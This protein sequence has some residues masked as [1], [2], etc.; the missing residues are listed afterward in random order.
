MS[1][2]ILFATDIHL[3][4]VKPVSRLDSDFLGGIIAKIEQIRE[5]SKNFDIVLLGGD[6]FDRPDSSHGVVTRAINVFYKFKTPVYS[7]V[8]NHDIYGYQGQTID[9]TA[10][11]VLIESGAVKKLDSI[12]MNNVAIYGLHA[13]DKTVWEVPDSVSTKVLVAHKMITNNPFPGGACHLISDVAN[14]TNA[15]L[16]LSGD[17]HYP[18]EVEIN[19]K[20]FLNPG[21][22][23]RL[24]ITDRDRFPQVAEITIEDSGDINYNLR[25]LDSRPAETVFDLANYS[26]RLASEEHTKHFVKTYAQAVI[27]VKAEAHLLAPMLE[28]FLM[29]NGVEARLHTMVDAYRDRA[30]KD[31]LTEMRE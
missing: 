19:G 23:A 28:K 9:K 16:I 31:V 12:F 24:S 29:E 10:M 3:R 6:I 13:Y 7:V 2:K 1:L 27:S 17:I 26:N 5:V 22:L 21:S 15:D 25:I 8:G 11:G 4:A 20:L 18:H 30:E 14:K